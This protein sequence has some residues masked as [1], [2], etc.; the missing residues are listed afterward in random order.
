MSESAPQ[1][2]KA[3]REPAE[4]NSKF[5]PPRL[6]TLLTG[7]KSIDKLVCLLSRRSM[8]PTLQKLSEFQ[9]VYPGSETLTH[10]LRLCPNTV[11]MNAQNIVELKPAGVS[12]AKE[13]SRLKAVVG[14][15]TEH[16][17]KEVYQHWQATAEEESASAFE[18]RAKK[19]WKDITNGERWPN[20]LEMIED[21]I[22]PPSAAPLVVPLPS[23][24]AVMMKSSSPSRSK[25]RALPL[26]LNDDGG[27]SCISLTD[28]DY[29][30]FAF[31]D[32]EKE[33]EKEKEGGKCPQEE[34]GG[35]FEIEGGATG[36]SSKNNKNRSNTDVILG[37]IT[38]LPWY[39]DQLVYSTK[40]PAHQAR[41]R[42]L[43][44]EPP[45][46]PQ[47]VQAVQQNMGLSVESGLYR[48][49]AL[50]IDALRQGKHLTLSTATSSGKSL[51]YNL[52]VLEAVLLDP[53]STALYL[54]PTKALAQDQLRATDAM[55]GRDGASNRVILPVVSAICDGD[56]GAAAREA[57]KMETTRGGANVILTNPDMLHHTILPQ[58]ASFK[59]IFKS[60]RFVVIDEAH[61]YRGT[62]G[63]HVACVLRR[64]VRTCLLY[65]MQPPQ[66]IVCSATISR[67]ADLFTSLLPMDVLGGPHCLQVVD[68]SDGGTAQG[69]RLFAMWNP[70]LT[71]CGARKHREQQQQS[72]D[73]STVND[74]S[75]DSAMDS[76]DALP[77]PPPAHPSLKTI[78]PP[79]DEESEVLTAAVNSN[80]SGK[81][82]KHSTSV[83][84]SEDSALDEFLEACEDRFRAPVSW[85]GM[86][87][88][89]PRHRVAYQEKRARGWDRTVEEE[90]LEQGLGEG[91]LARVQRGGDEPVAASSFEAKLSEHDVI[92][93]NTGVASPAA[94]QV[95]SREAGKFVTERER[96]SPFVEIARLLAYLVRLRLR[97]LC[98]CG[99]R[100]L[101]EMVNRM[102]RHELEHTYA[103]PHLL[104]SIA[105]YRGGYTAKDRR[106]IESRLF[107]GQLLGVC[108]TCALELGVDVGSLDVTLHLGYPGSI[109]SLWQ[110]AG[111][112]GRGGRPSLSILVCFD[113]PVDQYFAR[114][115]EKLL[116]A[117]VEGVVLGVDNP[118]VIRGHLLCAAYEERLNS[119]KLAASGLL[120]PVLWGPSF[121][122]TVLALLEGGHLALTTTQGVS[123]S[124]SDDNLKNTR[125][126]LRFVFATAGSA[127]QAAVSG[128]ALQLRHS[129]A[130][131]SSVFEKPSRCVNLRLIDPINIDIVDTG[132]PPGSV[133][134]H[135]NGNNYATGK[136]IDSM[137]Y[138][139]AFFEAFPGSVFYHQARQYLITSLDLPSRTALCHKVRLDYST[140][141]LN[142]TVVTIVHDASAHDC[143]DSGGIIS[144]GTVSVVKKVS[145]FTKRHI[146]T[147]ELL[148]E[149]EF[150]LPPLEMETQAV[151]I[152]L[153][154]SVKKAM[155]GAGHNLSASL[156]AA[157]HAFCSVAAIES[158][159]DAGDLDCEHFGT[160]ALLGGLQPRRMLCYDRRPGGLG[161]CE[162]LVEAGSETLRKA[163][164]VLQSCQCTS[165]LGKGCPSCLLDGRCS[166][167]N[168]N[169]SKD[170]A[171]MLLGLLHEASQISS[172]NS[173]LSEV[174]T[175]PS[176]SDTVRPSGIELTP[177]ELRRRALARQA[178]FRD[179]HSS[180]GLY[181]AS[182]WSKAVDE[183]TI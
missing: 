118:H 144:F 117:P 8:A 163:R 127:E 69:E 19:Q 62:F 64:L 131:I 112:A 181:V 72:S 165:P 58:H 53:H 126:E 43:C 159:C 178:R 2:K 15:V 100:N 86:H 171:I 124:P 65:R 158:L 111:R 82:G 120:E 116:R 90:E 41:Y 48:H 182:A 168:E 88:D 68:P 173:K 155:E 23:S 180:R 174:P 74:A 87:G 28:R 136:L 108:A 38:R 22:L 4:V 80:S 169:L 20:D 67:P 145:G 6:S 147:R 119:H 7:F 146:R 140:S 36:D 18:K 122:D 176:A 54:F 33:K 25:A 101:V 93:R 71:E 55:C 31:D 70:S 1:T 160:M 9:G 102:A 13:Q 99:T 97:V 94:L 105:S 113:S 21:L 63:A 121:G 46:P 91:V 134:A 135:N 14:A 153:P 139:R 104:E 32:E 109:S 130:S 141:A 92:I 89:K 12:K 17:R 170:G 148:D 47:L 161:I 27:S 106:E 133:G 137:S 183:T 73:E 61:C 50:A 177:R 154:L 83:D 132:G 143:N 149:G 42:S 85:K 34:N 79:M 152:D 45:L 44:S 107:S 151:W 115:P 142:D 56:S 125:K 51:V 123:L 172:S 138:S 81:D 164:E 162:A 157:N 166:H 5:F 3:K 76:G 24:P 114:F 26:L 10:L 39:R 179:S 103:A 16:A 11:S 37:S 57:V 129:S 52:P 98:F 78:A 40:Y 49:Q 84:K 29:S 30:S 156:H 59:R 66:F 128:E 150:N 75:N 95:A 110:Q 77:P 96:E 35:G 167:Y 175:S 60:L